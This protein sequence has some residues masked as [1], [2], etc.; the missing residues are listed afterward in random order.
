MGWVRFKRG[1]SKGAVE[2]LKR[3]YALAHDPEIAAHLAE[4]LWKNGARQDA[5]AVLATALS[6]N[7]DSEQLKKT[8]ARL[9]PP[10]KT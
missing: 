7:P 10:E 8:I 3:S 9:A 1:D 5:R 6:R 4:A 2:H